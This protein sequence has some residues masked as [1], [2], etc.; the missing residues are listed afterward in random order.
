KGIECVLYEPALKADSFFH[1]RNIKSLD[2][3]KKISDV[4]VANR[5]HPDLED[6]KDK[7]FTRDLFTR[8]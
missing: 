5:M 8:D 2:E 7:V 3:F 1:S 4:I 6:V